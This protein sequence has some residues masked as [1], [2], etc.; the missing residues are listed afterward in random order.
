MIL[1][2]LVMG[3]RSSREPSLGWPVRVEEG[4]YM[5][6]LP[7]DLGDRPL[8]TVARERAALSEANAV[9]HH[10]GTLLVRRNIPGCLLHLSRELRRQGVALSVAHP[11]G[12]V[13]AVA[14]AA[15]QVHR[16]LWGH[17]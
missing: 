7:Q 3:W 6:T 9:A 12:A 8:D 2:G 1:L 4:F 11:A 10:V 15:N 14:L 5:H 17:E 13:S 16:G